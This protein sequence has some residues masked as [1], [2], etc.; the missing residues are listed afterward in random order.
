MNCLEAVVALHNSV[1]F[2]RQF[3]AGPGG[4]RDPGRL[5]VA[6]GATA[7]R[8]DGVAGAERYVRGGPVGVAVPVIYQRADGSAHVIAA[9][10]AGERGEHGRVVLLDAQ[11]GEV[12]EAA[13][14]L[15]AAGVWVIPVSGVEVEGE[16]VLPSS[17]SGLRSPDGGSG[18][19]AEVTGPKRRGGVSGPV[20]GKAGA[21]GTKRTRGEAAQGSREEAGEG[22]GVSKRRKVQEPAAVGGVSGS[23]GDGGGEVLTPTDQAVQQDPNAER[24]RKKNERN[25]KYRRAVREDAARVVELEGKGLGQLTEEEKKELAE[26]QPRVAQRKQKKKEESAK[27][28][29]MGREDAVRVVELEGKGLGQLTEEEKK[30][31]AELQPRV[32]QRKQKK[33]E[34]N[35]KFPRARK[36]A[37]V[38]VVELEE[39]KEQGLLTVEQEAELAELRPKAQQWQKKKEGNAKRHRAMM[40]AVVRVVELE[41]LKEQGLLTVEQEAELAELRPKAQQWQKKKEWSTD[42]YWAGKAAAARVVVLEDLKGRGLLTVEQEAELAELRPKAQQ[43]QKQKEENVEWHRARKAAAARVVVLEDLKGRGLLTVEQEAELAELRPKAQ[44]WQKQKEENVEWHRARKAAA[45]RVVVLEDLKGRGPLTVEQE[46][47][48]AELRPKVAQRKQQ[49]TELNV[50]NYRAK[51]DAAVRVAELEALEGLT[52]AQAAELVELRPKAQQWQKKK[53]EKAEWNR[54]RKA[55]AVRVAVLEALEGLTEAQ[56]AELAELRPKAQ[57]WQKQKERFTDWYRAGKAAAVRVAVLEELA[58]R[59]LLT[60]ALEVELAELRPKAQQWQKKKED[61]A[62]WHRAKRAAAVRVAELEALEGLTEE[63]EV[64]LAELRARVAGRGR[65]KKGR[66]VAETGVGGP[67]VGRGAGPEGVSGWAG[68]DY[69]GRDVWSADVDLDAWLARVVPDE[70]GV[71]VPQ[72]AADAGVMLDEGAYEE[73]VETELLAFLGQDAGDDA[74]GADGAGSVAGGF[75]FADFLSDYSEGRVPLGCLG[76]TVL[77]GCFSVSRLRGMRCGRMRGCGG[78]WGVGGCRSGS[79]G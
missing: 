69:D 37:A 6:F 45:A 1:K 19:P 32:A 71:Q 36:A 35:A 11:K 44:Q 15:A 26:L 41:E 46:T 23:P 55:A 76:V 13:D 29:R 50:K 39:L 28:R 79:G 12:A 56:A 62:E 65:E 72:G 10:H 59:G 66:E 8:V 7:R 70:E 34:E 5:E 18:L 60:E 48:L 9:V 27:Y 64:E 20:A 57:Q 43:W 78:V 49:K 77:T 73:F 42:W 25:A 21:K 58:G 63:Q 40:A 31:L 22:S 74:A 3:V 30:E 52:E 33:K 61:N 75:D 4:D 14:V 68:A 53:E 24:K 38:R 54:A 16:V 67:V 47:E 51:M 17:G 2:G